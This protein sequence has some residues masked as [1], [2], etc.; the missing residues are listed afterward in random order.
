MD[1]SKPT[2]AKSGERPC[3]HTSPLG[4]YTTKFALRVIQF[5]LSVAM[6]GLV[7][8]TM[9][10]GFLGVGILIVSAPATIVSMCWS[11]SEMICI[12]VRGGHRGIHPGACVAVDL[13]LWLAFIGATA[14]LSLSQ[15]LDDAVA[16]GKALIGLGATLVILHFATFVIACYETNV[17]NRKKYAATTTVIYET[18]TATNHSMVP[19]THM[20]T[21]VSTYNNTAVVP[22]HTV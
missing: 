18:S 1:Y 9:Q 13:L 19:I 17:R 11:L 15:T 8:S 12:Y 21:P 22:I 7:G 10:A 14:M 2:P 4:M 16:K 5:V 6:V 3:P 20:N